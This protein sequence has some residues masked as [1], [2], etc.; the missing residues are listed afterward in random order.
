MTHTLRADAVSLT[1]TGPS[2]PPGSALSVLF[3]G[4]RVWSFRV[5]DQDA[6][7]DDSTF[8]LAWPPMLAE[9]LTG[10][11][12][13]SLEQSGSIVAVDVE[14]RFDDVDAEFDL[15]DPASGIPLIVNKWGRISHSF[16]G[17]E[18]S[19][20][21][22]V[23]D[24][25]QRLVALV[26]D[27]L[28]MDLFV[29]GGTLLGPVRDGAIMPHD[30]DADLAYL[31]E[32]ENPSDLALESFAI[33]RMLVSHGYEVVRLSAV[34]LQLMFPGGTVT[35]RFYI[36]IF[37]YFVTGGWFY[38]TFHAREPAD[39]V[40]ILP[41]QP[42]TVNGRALPGPANPA[43]LL[44]AIYGPGWAVPDA[45]FTFVTPPPARRRYI[46]WFADLNMD[47][48]NWE[49]YHRGEI[50]AGVSTDPSDFAISTAR[51]LQPGSTVVELGC[52]LAADAPFLAA[53]GHTVL[54]T[55][56][57]RPVIAYGRGL[58]AGEAGGGASGATDGGAS[59]VRRGAASD[60]QPGAASGALA[61]PLGC[62]DYEC[63]N[64]NAARETGAVLQRLAAIPDPV[65][66]YA[67]SLFDSLS[68]E[69]WDVALLFMKHLLSRGDSRAY[70]EFTEG[71]QHRERGWSEYG[72]VEWPH[73]ER[74]L[75]R[76]GLMVE[77]REVHPVNPRNGTSVNRVIV[78]VRADD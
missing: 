69:G 27:E 73:F 45:A 36:D 66:V 35:D 29:T 68:P 25:T 6:E 24:E 7:S 32:Y 52:G 48:E 31:S 17:Q 34:H 19:V 10:R 67:R 8:T 50:S 76:H 55:D 62:L 71:G 33:E 13:L 46:G 61:A 40:T 78:K 5:P 75:H 38:G 54:A 43:Q 21:E 9:R 56:Y 41:L 72:A 60:V 64:L 57:S 74:E 58:L 49:S 37:T 30:D 3:A 2:L 70:L 39:Q 15:R 42:V 23:L 12:T 53:Q 4:R 77:D 20:I 26:R 11:T 47:R 65:H 18:T 63:V 1:V 14:V 51:R 44:A 22:D 28:G 16:A 59:G